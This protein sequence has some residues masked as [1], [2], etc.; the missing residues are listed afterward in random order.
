M[1]KPST[2]LREGVEGFLPMNFQPAKRTRDQVGRG[3][4]LCDPLDAVTYTHLSL[5]LEV[6]GRDVYPPTVR[7]V[8]CG[9]CG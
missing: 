1:E 5:I 7:C 9:R 6:E 3:R 8:T 4:N 2:P